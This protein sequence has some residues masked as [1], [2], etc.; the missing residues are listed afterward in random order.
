MTINQVTILAALGLAII[1]LIAKKQRQNV[2]E[3]TLIDFQD[4]PSRIGPVT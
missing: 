3:L 1:F 4:I 2:E